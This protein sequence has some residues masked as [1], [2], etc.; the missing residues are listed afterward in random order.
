MIK[1]LFSLAQKEFNYPIE[2]EEK[3]LLKD[4]YHYPSRVTIEYKNGNYGDIIIEE[5]N[6]EL[7]IM[8]YRSD[9]KEEDWV[10]LGVGICKSPEDCLKNIKKLCIKEESNG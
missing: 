8:Q 3:V 7:H 6:R 9:A 2:F 10:T 4:G 1:N 5:I